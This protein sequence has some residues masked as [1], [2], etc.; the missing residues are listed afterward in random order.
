LV[1]GLA[2]KLLNE[3]PRVSSQACF[4]IHNLAAAFQ[5]D[6]AAAFSGTNALSREYDFYVYVI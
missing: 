2:S 4:G 5:K 1:N 6:N 3:T